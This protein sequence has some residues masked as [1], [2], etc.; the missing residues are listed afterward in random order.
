LENALQ[1][2]EEAQSFTVSASTGVKQSNSDGWT[3]TSTQ[4]VDQINQ[5]SLREYETSFD[6]DIKHVT[7]CMS[8]TC[9]S[10]DATGLLKPVQSAYTIYRPKLNLSVKTYLKSWIP[11]YT[12]G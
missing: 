1:H 2:F 7:L 6:W 5:T 4:Y 9:Y 10:A 12:I 11:T 3:S 8:A